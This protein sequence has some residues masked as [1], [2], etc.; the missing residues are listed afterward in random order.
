MPAVNALVAVGLEVRLSQLWWALGGVLA[1]AIVGFATRGLGR[2]ARTRAAVR[3]EVRRALHGG[4]IEKPA[5][6]GAQV[7]GRLGPLEV[8]LELRND[9]TRPRQ[10]PM[11]RAL[12]VG[13]VAM[14]RPVE[15]RVAGWEGWIDPWLQLG[16]TLVVPPGAGPEFTLHAEG[17][18]TLDHPVVVALCRQ[19]DR[20]GPGAIHARPG[21]MR[22]ETR[23]CAKREEN[24]PLLAYLHAMAEISELARTRSP[25]GTAPPVSDH[26]VLPEGR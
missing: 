9:V 24:R 6:Q 8:T 3:E 4:V 11:W 1:I 14:E 13:P 5:G 19:G 17:L 26:G 20:L 12:A 16:D 22:V 18:P 2:S 10:S 21:L 15:A 7:R 23:F 25:L